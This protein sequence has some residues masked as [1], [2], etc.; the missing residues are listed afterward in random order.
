MIRFILATR[1]E[2][3]R[4]C[5]IKFGSELISSLYIITLFVT[6]INIILNVKTEWKF[7]ESSCIFFQALD[8]SRFKARMSSTKSARSISTKSTTKWWVASLESLFVEWISCL[9]PPPVQR[10]TRP[11]LYITSE[12]ASKALFAFCSLPVMLSRI[13]FPYN[14]EGLSLLFIF[15]T[16]VERT[17]RRNRKRKR[18]E[19]STVPPVREVFVCFPLQRKALS[20]RS[21]IFLMPPRINNPEVSS[22]WSSQY[23]LT[24]YNYLFPYEIFSKRLS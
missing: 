16:H 19:S 4:N 24:L 22:R 7:N 20:R 21:S 5:R 18:E 6:S 17:C 9:L 11:L 23:P 15:D 13:N 8:L 12:V 10:G 2:N 1:L 14:R 3:T